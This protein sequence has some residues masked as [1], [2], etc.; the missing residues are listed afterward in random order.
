[1]EKD[2][3]TLPSGETFSK[4]RFIDIDRIEYSEEH[5]DKFE[6][7]LC[8]SY[9]QKK[10]KLVATR[11][12]CDLYTVPLERFFFYFYFLVCFLF[13]VIVLGLTSNR[14]FRREFTRP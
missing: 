9:Q 8:Y 13:F 2:K 4:W 6:K 5:K 1:M 7:K 3:I 14:H 11:P 12:L 10:T